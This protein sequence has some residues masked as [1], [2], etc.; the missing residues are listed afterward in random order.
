MADTQNLYDVLGVSK[1]ASESEIKKAYRSLSLMYHPDRNSDPEAKSKFQ[2]ISA[3]Y[4]RLKDQQSRQQYN[5]ELENPFMKNM[6]PGPDMNDIN[7]IFSMFFNGGMGGPMGGMGG[8]NIRVFHGG[9][10]MGGEGF[11]PGFPPGIFRQVEK[12]QPNPSEIKSVLSI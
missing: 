7:N 9:H 6:G 8:P 5:M 11:P 4:E 10:P 3:A 12:P 1:D 2:E